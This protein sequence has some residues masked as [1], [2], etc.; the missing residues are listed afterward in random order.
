MSLEQSCRARKMRKNEPSVAKCRFGTAENE[1]YVDEFVMRKVSPSINI[2]SVR[3]GVAE[4][5]VG[6]AEISVVSLAPS[7]VMLMHR[8]WNTN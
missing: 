8:A 5:G 2:G 6:V 3:P 7:F 1:L 4:S